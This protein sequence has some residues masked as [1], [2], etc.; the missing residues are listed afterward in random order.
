MRIIRTWNDKTEGKAAGSVEAGRQ[1][2]LVFDMDG[3]LFDTEAVKMAAF[4]DAFAPLCDGDARKLHAVGEFNATH[5]GVPRDD[6]FRHVLA[7][8]LGAPAGLL[9]EVAARY[10][11]ALAERLPACEPVPGLVEF[12]RSMPATRYIASSAPRTEVVGNLA[13][14]GL[15]PDFA[16]IYAHP[17]SKERALEE[18]AL[19]HPAAPRVFF[20]D[21]PA[22]LAAA[23]STGTR[24]VAIN[25]NPQ[26]VAAAVAGFNDF[27]DIDAIADH[28]RAG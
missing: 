24:F 2:V 22:D 1:L 11:A 16:D 20:G 9:D 8:V 18:V 19:R 15:E 25:A 6:K 7:A 17:C 13:R 28:L 12:L 3:T 23:R 14:H 26:L 5:R 21:A 27:R 4:R 10:A